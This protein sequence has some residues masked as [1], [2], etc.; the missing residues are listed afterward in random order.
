LI[1]NSSSGSPEIPCILW[2]PKVKYHV[3]KINEYIR[4]QEIKKK[5]YEIFMLSVCPQFELL[6]IPPVFIKFGLPVVINTLS[7]YSW[8]QLDA[9]ICELGG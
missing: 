6:D 2:N 7:T 4:K 3:H 8:Q 1:S 5:D 9:Q